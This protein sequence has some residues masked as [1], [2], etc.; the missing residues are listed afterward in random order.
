MFD[1]PLNV[2]GNCMCPWYSHRWGMRLSEFLQ[3]PDLE[4]L[5]PPWPENLGQVLGS[6]LSPLSSKWNQREFIWERV[7]ERR[8]AIYCWGQWSD[9]LI[10]PAAERDLLCVM[11]VFWQHLHTEEGI[12]AL[13]RGGFSGDVIRKKNQ[14]DA[15]AAA[16]RWGRGFDVLQSGATAFQRSAWCLSA[17]GGTMSR[18]RSGGIWTKEKAKAQ[19]HFIS[20]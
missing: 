17:L 2:D 10:L 19:L 3:T 20:H 12:S 4:L 18:K 13:W 1:L 11:L 9:K 8:M 15:E 7:N 14:C 6:L 5:G 16:E